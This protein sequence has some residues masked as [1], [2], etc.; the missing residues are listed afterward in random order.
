MEKIISMSCASCSA[1]IKLPEDI[2]YFNC[3]YC[4]ASMKMSHGEGYIALKL[5]EE[6]NTVITNNTKATQ[7]E[8]NKSRLYQNIS[9]LEIQLSN[10][11]LAIQNLDRMA[12]TRRTKKQ[13]RE[14]I[15]DKRIIM[16][17]INN[18]K[19]ILRVSY[20]CKV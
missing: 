4:G 11:K 6:V 13:K 1:P 10:I 19:H 3:A 9:M 14:L 8:I 2:E 15:R 12:K 17:R 18:N 5:I 16:R 7:T 20:L